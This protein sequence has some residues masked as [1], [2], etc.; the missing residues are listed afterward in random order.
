MDAYASGEPIIS[1]A[2]KPTD[3]DVKSDDTEVVAMIKVEF[4]L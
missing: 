4:L 1:E 2:H 3:S